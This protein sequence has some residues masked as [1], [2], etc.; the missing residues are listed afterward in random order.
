VS[1][2][3]P[4]MATSAPSS[5]FQ[6]GQAG[7]RAKVVSPTNGKSILSG[8]LRLGLS[9]VIGMSLV[10]EMVAD[11]AAG[12]IIHLL[13]RVGVALWAKLAFVPGQC[14]CNFHWGRHGG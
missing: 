12:K 8:V 1:I 9:V 6:S 3:T 10:G 4:R 5:L 14:G 7:W 2:G 13:D 11:E